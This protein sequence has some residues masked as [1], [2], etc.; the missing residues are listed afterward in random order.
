MADGTT[1]DHQD[2]TS[3]TDTQLIEHATAR[4]EVTPLEN[5]LAH[6]LEIFVATFGDLQVEG[7][8]GTDT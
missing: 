6:R 8:D 7:F 4:E 5:E 1:D 2:M 3:M